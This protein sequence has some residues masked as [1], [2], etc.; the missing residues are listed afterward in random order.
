M[1]QPIP[2]PL[3]TA[4]W[5]DLQQCIENL[6]IAVPDAVCYD[7]GIEFLCGYLQEYAITEQEAHELLVMMA[8]TGKPMRES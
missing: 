2:A 7:V 4:A 5:K 1:T 6:P 8:V 3:L